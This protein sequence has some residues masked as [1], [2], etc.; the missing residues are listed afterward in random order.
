MSLNLLQQLKNY[1]PR[2]KWYLFDIDDFLKKWIGNSLSKREERILYSCIYGNKSADKERYFQKLK[3][4][5]TSYYSKYD[6][7]IEYVL[8]ATL[9]KD[10]EIDYAGIKSFFPAIYN[11]WH[12]ILKDYLEYLGLKS[13][14][15]KFY[16][17]VKSETGNPKY[18]WTTNFDLFG[19]SINPEHIH[20][21]FLSEMKK[22][23]NV[24]YKIIN[25]GKEY[26]FKYIW[27]HNGIGKLNTIQQLKQ[28]D[29]CN[30]FFDFDYFFDNS[31]RMNRM[32]IYGM[33]FQ[34]S[35]YMDDLKL[36]LSKYK[37]ASLGG[38]IDE[39]I[40]LRINA[41]QE[42][43][44]L[45][46]VDITYFSENEKQHLEEVMEAVKI[47]KYNLVRCQDFSFSID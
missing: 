3:E 46:E 11:I 32:L 39:H 15:D 38:I 30:L 22:Y 31:V 23:D 37:K 9:F 28:Y 24:V 42:L 43:G 2:D 36:T 44:L 1:T 41:M 26:Y 33:S 25:N 27:G 7:N 16:L 45:N 35:G 14:V 18:I 6:A 12:I 8:G 5:M 19:E 20:G 21:R 17:S 40:L 13:Q 29:D 4:E 47:K 10:T 34:N